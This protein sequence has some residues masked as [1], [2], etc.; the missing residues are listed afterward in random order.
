[1]AFANLVTWRFWAFWRL[2]LT[3]AF[4]VIL[5]L[6]FGGADANW[7]FALPRKCQ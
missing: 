3:T 1:M 2:D 5:N 6:V 7:Q 4:L